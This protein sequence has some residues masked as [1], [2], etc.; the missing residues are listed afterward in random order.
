LRGAGLSDVWRYLLGSEEG[1]MAIIFTR[2]LEQNPGV[3]F[4]GAAL[5]HTFRQWYANPDRLDGCDHD[6]LENMDGMLRERDGEHDPFGR[7]NLEPSVIEKLSTLPD[8]VCYLSRYSQAIIE[9][10]FFAGLGDP[11]NQAHF[12]HLM[13]DLDVFMVNNVP[14]RDRKLARKIFPS[15][16]IIKS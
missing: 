10:P 5:A 13:Y 16:T 7:K 4:N 2:L 3:L 14:F 12:F 11:I 9:D 1:D 6:M 15:G 8:D